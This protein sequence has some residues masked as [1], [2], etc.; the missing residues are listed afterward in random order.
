MPPLARGA[1]A[2][3]LCSGLMLLGGCSAGPDYVRPVT[4]TPAAF[5]EAGWKTAEPKDM[6]IKGKW[7]EIYNNPELNA[8]EEQVTV[9]NQNVAAAEARYRQ[10]K[11]LTQATRAALFPTAGVSAT[12]S[13]SDTLTSSSG[14]PTRVISNSYLLTGSFSWELDLWGKTRRAVE[15]SEAS[16]QA[17]AAD[18]AAMR[19]SMQSSLMQDYFQLRALDSQKMLLDRTIAEYKKFLEIT[20]NRYATG[21]AGQSDVLNAETQLSNAQAQAIET[22]VQR[23]QLEHAIA[24]LAGKPPA[25]F[26]LPLAPLAV[27]P[28]AIPIGVPSDLLERRP[29]IASAERA[30]AAANAQIGVAES[31]YYPAISLNGAGGFDATRFS[32][33]L[34]WPSRYWS[35]GTTLSETLFDAGLRGAQT[36]QAIAAY[37]AIVATY[38]Q[39]V[40]A[41][42]QEVEDNLAALRIL[43]QEAQVQNRTVQSSQKS[44][45][46]TLNQYSAGI[47]SSLDVVTTQTIALNNQ[48]TAIGLKSRLLVAHGMLI[49][50]LGGGW[51]AS[52]LNETGREGPK[53]EATVSDRAEAPGPEKK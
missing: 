50:A 47:A 15:S 30:M 13:R 37:E 31:A 22:T 3:L 42:F 5:K 6:Q 14:T 29:D 1:A 21:V 26:S 46:I 33:W 16:A 38:R 45:A 36:D 25:S 40:L 44:A 52:Q 18:L 20:K 41:G 11:A 4:E 32:D 51:D 19:L 28:P 27:D 48:V 10:A 23:A 49:N 2:L 34:V 53:E 24:V 43:S 12:P 9:S 35:I 7:W 8:L 17:S 39:T